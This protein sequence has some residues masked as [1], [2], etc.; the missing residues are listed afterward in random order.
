MNVVS[1]AS[2]KVDPVLNINNDSNDARGARSSVVE[3]IWDATTIAKFVE[4]TAATAGTVSSI[5]QD[6]TFLLPL[7]DNSMF[8]EHPKHNRTGTPADRIDILDAGAHEKS[9]VGPVQDDGDSVDCLGDVH[10]RIEVW[11]GKVCHGQ[12]SIREKHPTATLSVAYPVDIFVCG[13]ASNMITYFPSE[14]LKLLRHTDTLG[15][16][17]WRQPLAPSLAT[18]PPNS[19]YLPAL[20]VQP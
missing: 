15:M 5:W 8:R 12:V 1:A 6:E 13:T 14:P 11:Q 9:T 16:Q 17:N 10:L 3:R 4:S 2:I 20:C 7:H 19:P 18:T